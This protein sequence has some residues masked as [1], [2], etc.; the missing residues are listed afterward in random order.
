MKAKL[1]TIWMIVLIAALA[2]AL[3]NL[4][5]P[6]DVAN[7]ESATNVNISGVVTWVDKDGRTHNASDVTVEILVDLQ[8]Y[9]MTLPAARCRRQPS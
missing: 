5:L 9:Y 1:K 7:A 2:F 8:D 6:S 4:V 3:A